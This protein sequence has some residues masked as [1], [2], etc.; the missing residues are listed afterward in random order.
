[1]VKNIRP[2]T[3]V[4]LLASCTM[5]MMTGHSMPYPV[6]APW[7][8]AHNIGMGALG[9][10][11]FAFSLGNLIAAPGAGYL[12][13]RWGRRPVLII[14]L[15]AIV[16]VNLVTPFVDDLT[17]FI[18]LRFVLGFGNAGIMPAAL[19]ATADI[20]P[21]ERRA[22]WIGYVSGGISIGL[23][24]GPTIGGVLYDAL[25]F[26]APF[27]VSGVMAFI[28]VVLVLFIVPE[29]R[30][31][32]VSDTTE[33][34]SR[35]GFGDIWRNPPRPLGVLVTLLVVEFAWT[36][37]W[38]ATEPAMIRQLYQ[39]YAYTATMFGVVVGV[40]GA[41][42]ALGEFGFGGL[43]DR[44]G[45][46]VLIAIGLIFH[47]AWYIGVDQA[48]QYTPLIIASIIAGLGSGLVTPAI[49]AAYVDI[50]S[51]DQ[52]GRIAALKEIVLSLG[53]M[54]GPLF[55]AFTTDYLPPAYFFRGATAMILLAS[56]LAVVMIWR[57]GRH[58]VAVG[59]PA[60]V[61]DAASS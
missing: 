28:A 18:V 40:H 32:L 20:A 7:L 37:A 54:L 23:I 42:T 22:Q 17:T 30:P 4:L 12:V 29:T 45:R 6:L 33:G 58:L 50:S 43:S 41:A 46:F 61:G 36:F 60:S 19:A 26:A 48:P 5:L 24:I 44:F 10:M 59:A 57:Y 52:R 27:Y 25:G 35:S 2:M 15:L 1:M 34:P 55:A 21:E 14:G 39:Q 49:G 47:T 16:I 53:G 8:I 9:W 31:A 3:V 38:V 13:D 11:S 56:G 51:A